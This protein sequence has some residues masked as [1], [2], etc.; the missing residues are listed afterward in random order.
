MPNT[1]DW[2]FVI[3]GNHRKAVSCV[4]NRFK[5]KHMILRTFDIRDSTKKK[6]YVNIPYSLFGYGGMSLYLTPT[7]GYSG[8]FETTAYSFE[9]GFVTCVYVWYGS[10]KKLR[11]SEIQVGDYVK[12]PKNGPIKRVIDVYSMPEDNCTMLCFRKPKYDF[13]AENNNKL[14]VL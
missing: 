12:I 6:M 1:I 4:W 5:D 9:N 8:T 2:R 3:F 14:D 10:I 13:D 11:V 7:S